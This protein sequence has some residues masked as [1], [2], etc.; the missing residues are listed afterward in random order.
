MIKRSTVTVLFIS[1]L[2][3]V[4]ILSC[5]RSAQIP[6]IERED[7]FTLD[8]GKLEDQIAL[9]NLDGNRSM[10]RTDI[11][12][13]NGLFYISDGNGSKILKYNSFGDLLFMIYN[14]ET[15]PQPLTLKPLTEGSVVTRWAV[16]YPLQE[17]GEITVDSRKHIYV[18][19][20]LPYERHSFDT[21]SKA[22]LDSVILHF[23]ADGKFVEYLGREGIGGSPFP[24]IEGLYT[25]IR[26]ELAVVC[27]LPTGWN[28]YWYDSQGIFLFMVQLKNESVPVPQDRENVIP[29]L[30]SVSVGPDARKLYVKVDYY[31]NTYDESTNTRTGIEPDSSVIWI[32]N[33]ES[34]VWEKHMDVPFFEYTYTEQNKKVTTKMIYSLLGV[35]NNGKVFFSFPVEGGYSILVMPT[36]TGTSSEQHQGFIRVDGSELQFNVF[37]LSAD[38]ILSGLLADDYQVKLVWWRTDKFLGDK[39]Q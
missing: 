26:D 5:S 32:M 7:L 2:F 36:E 18:T 30:D 25:S 23:D 19:D 8:I 39:S 33:A 12:M 6:S 24:R 4:I 9:F 38:G 16:P 22:L 1:L 11:A 17:P 31:R 37:D 14:D 3:G 15:N 10:R 13:R 28:I 34:G 35:M 29:S 20:R 21:E 27:R